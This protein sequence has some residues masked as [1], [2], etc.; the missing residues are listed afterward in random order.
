MLWFFKK[1]RT[2]PPPKTPMEKQMELKLEADRSEL[3]SARENQYCD[4]AQFMHYS[5]EE[6]YKTPDGRIIKKQTTSLADAHNIAR[7]S[8]FVFYCYLSQEELD[9]ELSDTALPCE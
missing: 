5:K 3:I 2:A 1:R 4:D 9:Q 7:N 8:H 6:Y